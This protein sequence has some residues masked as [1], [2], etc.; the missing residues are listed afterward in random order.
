MNEVYPFGK[1]SIHVPLVGME[2]T[3][4]ARDRSELRIYGPYFR[5]GNVAQR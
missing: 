1:Q 3:L 2:S 4:N 5:A